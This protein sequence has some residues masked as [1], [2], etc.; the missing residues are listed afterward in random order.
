VIRAT[1]AQ[2]G[3]TERHGAQ[4]RDQLA[5]EGCRE[6]LIGECV[7]GAGAAAAAGDRHH[8]IIERSDMAKEAA[9]RTVVGGVD[10]NRACAAGQP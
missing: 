4:M 10:R 2:G 1:L 5:R 3:Q 6:V 7:S 8:E 9:Q